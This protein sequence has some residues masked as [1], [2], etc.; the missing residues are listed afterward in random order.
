MYDGKTLGTIFN[1]IDRCIRKHD[2]TKYER[3]EYVIMLKSNISNIIIQKS[4]Q[5]MFF[6]QEN[7]EYTKFS[8]TY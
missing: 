5:M 7:V 1:K 8:D 3:I 6:L 4:F 2:S